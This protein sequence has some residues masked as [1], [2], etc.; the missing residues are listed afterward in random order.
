MTRIPFNIPAVLGTET[1]Y[2]QKILTQT[3]KFS[4]DGPF[5][6]KTH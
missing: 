1:T 3:I 6:K 4:G 2:I 5:T